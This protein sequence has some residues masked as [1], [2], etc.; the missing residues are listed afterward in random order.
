M[1]CDYPPA[2]LTSHHKDLSCLLWCGGLYESVQLITKSSS[3]TQIQRRSLPKVGGSFSRE[4][5]DRLISS[6]GSMPLDPIHGSTSPNL[7]T[8]GVN[9]CLLQVAT[10]EDPGG[11]PPSRNGASPNPILLPELSPSETQASLGIFQRR[12][13]EFSDPDETAGLQPVIRCGCCRIPH[14][15]L[16]QGIEVSRRFGLSLSPFPYAC[17]GPGVDDVTSTRQP[18]LACPTHGP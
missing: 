6:Q 5:V 9:S 16:P 12:P 18:S 1:L 4:S 15:C 2:P 17:Q 7:L 8:Y 11:L 14:D 3:P 13:L 10:G